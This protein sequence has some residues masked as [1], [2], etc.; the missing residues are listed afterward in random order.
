MSR[1]QCRRVLTRIQSTWCKIKAG[2]FLSFTATS[3]SRGPSHHTI[4]FYYHH[5]R[6]SIV[7]CQPAFPAQRYMSVPGS[8]VGKL[9]AVLRDTPADTQAA[10]DAVLGKIYQYLIAVPAS[11]DK[12]VHWF[13][14][15]ADSTTI[16]AATFLIRLMAYNSVQV[17]EWKKRLHECLTH[18]ALC[19]QGLETAKVTS[20]ETFLAAFN[21]STLEAFFAEFNKWELREVWN[22]IERADQTTTLTDTQQSLSVS[23]P[24]G[25]LYRLVTNWT[26]FQDPRILSFLQKGVLSV[27]LVNLA[28]Y[29]IP[30]GFLVL[31]LADNSQLRNWAVTQV[32]QSTMIRSGIFTGAYIEAMETILHVVSTYD[33]AKSTPS[34]GPS[35]VAHLQFASLSELWSGFNKLLR[36]I[37]P[38]W[39]QT[40]THLPLSLR[41]TVLGHLHDEGPHFAD[42]LA[43][44]TFLLKR[45]GPGLW[46]TG[47]KEDAQLALAAILE[48]TCFIKL[49]LP[50]ETTV[51]NLTWIPEYLM[52][53]RR[54][55]AYKVVLEKATRFLCEDSREVSFQGIRPMLMARSMRILQQE[56]Q[57]P[58]G[59]H[60][61]TQ[62]CMVLEVLESNFSSV[63]SLAYDNEFNDESWKS[64]RDSAQVLVKTCLSSSVQS[65]KDV[66]RE[67]C[68][69]LGQSKQDIPVDPLPIF[70]FQGEFWRAFYSITPTPDIIAFALRIVAAAAHLDSLKPSVFKQ[71]FGVDPLLN[72]INQ[73][74]ETLQTG[75]STWISSFAEYNTSSNAVDILGRDNIGKA[76]TL[77][78][79]SPK[80]GFRTAGK[81]LI[82]LAFDV[83][84][85]LECFRA[86]LGKYPV[87]SLDGLFHFLNT[88]RGYA[89]SIPEAS[90]L[91]AALVRCFA[92]V[93][94]ALCASSDGL[95]HDPFFLRVKDSHGPASR[96]PAFW[97][98]LTESLTLIYSRAPMWATYVDTPD[99]VLWMRDALILA[100]DV[101]KQWRVVEKASNQ[102]EKLS[103]KAHTLGKVSPL[104]QRLIEDLQTF[105]PQLIRWLRLTDE[106]LLHQ[107]FTL[108]QSVFNLMK[109]T[110]IAPSI[111]ALE[112]LQ[113]LVEG[114]KKS[115]QTGEK[116]THLDRGRLLQLSDL[117]EHFQDGDKEKDDDISIISHTVPP[118]EAKPQKPLPKPSE[119]VPR[120]IQGKAHSIKTSTLR[121]Q[122]T[123]PFVS[124]KLPESKFTENDQ[125]KLDFVSTIPS[126]RKSTSTTPLAGSSHSLYDHR[127]PRTKVEPKNEALNQPLGLVDGS[128][129]SE[130]ESEEDVDQ[131]PG[132]EAF[133]EPSKP[134]SPKMKSSSQ[135]HPR[136]K[137]WNELE[138]AKYLQSKLSRN[139]PLPS[140][141]AR[142]PPDLSSFYKVVLSWDYNHTDTTP[143]GNR[144][145]PIQVP[146]RFENY[147]HYFRVF[148]PLLLLECWAQ[149]QQSKEEVRDTYQAKVVS[150]THVDKWLDV[151][152][153][154]SE[155][156]KKEWYLAET[157]IVLLRRPGQEKCV[158]AKVK[159]YV[160]DRKGIQATLRCYIQTGVGDPG[161]QI[162]TLWQISKVLSLS[163]LN[164]EYEAL[165]SLRNN[166]DLCD[167]ILRPSFPRVPDVD[168][169]D[170]RDTM[171]T[172]KTSRDR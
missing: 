63:I 84:D 67:L 150:R 136:V 53:V 23:L 118:K 44:F 119:D 131:G 151:G 65:L 13:C 66:I 140:T 51:K 35:L 95:L 132:T 147:E 97:K 16:D 26:I 107:S 43:C 141:T 130:S 49:L 114:A 112:K 72:K 137:P 37:P 41:R 48:N 22:D 128:D 163:T 29:P 61:A 148:Q 90:S 170:I 133:K 167:F 166:P 54:L 79:L 75:F 62:S 27:H 125:L 8:D 14:T 78:L 30:P 85:R 71:L 11:S 157:D 31:L 2:H 120:Y 59:D 33:A 69:H 154:I 159:S 109:E 74:L 87:E 138:Q 4:F 123:L 9:L 88:F 134:E 50:P 105:L 98:S 21:K 149:L 104:G 121:T 92:D 152:I 58:Q 34:A 99:M 60:D 36:V 145:I 42:V 171:E 64:A 146:D 160:A 52:T 57:R 6:V 100:R 94:E 143:P 5:G 110:H 164:R 86:M 126:F 24:V 168:S 82:G 142:L 39:F 10:S 162:S 129:S 93:L 155:S 1:V 76:V 153:E 70:S 19:V 101:L 96:M 17:T 117:L 144:V 28:D 77:L 32:S 158:M 127:K 172:Y 12:H 169:K 68:R 15:Q 73:G 46:A 135:R 89:S 122:S 165:Q 20:Q 124:T 115:E 45:L 102:Y 91:S 113:N 103:Y 40:A 80:Q 81:T 38:E 156:V 47:E 25:T 139:R 56:L 116:K 106:E 161:V 55:S 3:L 111:K 108:L 7:Y 18:C 83:D